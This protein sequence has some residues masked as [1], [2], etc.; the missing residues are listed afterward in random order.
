MTLSLLINK[1]TQPQH[2]VIQQALTHVQ[3]VLGSQTQMGIMLEIPR[4]LWKKKYRAQKLQPVFVDRADFWVAHIFVPAEDQD[5]VPDMLQ[6]IEEEL[7]FRRLKVCTREMLQY[8]FDFMPSFSLK[9]LPTF[10][11]ISGFDE[12]GLAGDINTRLHDIKIRLEK[13]LAIEFLSFSNQHVIYKLPLLA[14][15]D[16]QDVDCESNIA[17]AYAGALEKNFLNW[18]PF[19]NLLVLGDI[20]DTKKIAHEASLLNIK[21]PEHANANHQ[22]SRLLE[23]LTQN[24]PVSLPEAQAMLW[25]DSQSNLGHLQ[26]YY[27]KTMPLP[28]NSPYSAIAW[29]AE[30]IVVKS[31]LQNPLYMEESSSQWLVSTAESPTHKLI[32]GK[33]AFVQHQDGYKIKT[34]TE[35]N[36]W[37][38]DRGKQHRDLE[39]ISGSFVDVQILNFQLID[40]T[41]KQP[42]QLSKPYPAET[43]GTINLETLKNMGP[44]LLGKRPLLQPDDHPEKTLIL[45]FPVL[46]ELRPQAPASQLTNER[47]KTQS[48]GLL[49]LEDLIG[50]FMSQNLNSISFIHTTYQ[51]GQDV[52]QVL[53]ELGEDAVKTA[54][55]GCRVIILDD[56]SGFEPGRVA[57]DI[58]LALQAVQN[59]LIAYVGKID[60]CLRRSCTIVVRTHE[61]QSLSDIEKFL[62]WG[63][64]AVVPYRIDFD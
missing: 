25:S 62:E 52:R 46:S 27:Q 33:I 34:Q 17:L 3:N 41:L 40:Q 28:Q 5:M 45:P 4:K 18:Q 56:S 24:F 51:T 57:C 23:G 43:L 13:M 61:I 20:P 30:C 44:T 39:K 9:N 59:A 15:G 64:N 26:D 47:K 37:T 60:Q 42:L 35:L 38:L 19:S 49:L 32:S 2:Q 21:F 58:R 1:N 53:K 10:L 14:F 12:S 31:T 63:A 11:Q 55:N 29:D 7:T 6:A 8:E 36:Q 50:F 48:Q 54:L 16:L 22:L